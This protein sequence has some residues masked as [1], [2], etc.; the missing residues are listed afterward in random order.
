MKNIINTGKEFLKQA[1]WSEMVLL[2]T[3]VFTAGILFGRALPKKL[4]RPVVFAAMAVFVATYV[5][6]ILKFL[7]ILKKDNKKAQ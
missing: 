3:C 2:K 7:E 6:L 1:S 5:P 4:G